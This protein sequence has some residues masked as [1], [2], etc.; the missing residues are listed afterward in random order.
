MRYNC[1]IR[2]DGWKIGKIRQYLDKNN[3]KDTLIMSY[4]VKY[5]S[6]MYGPFR[7]LYRQAQNWVLIKILIKWT[8]EILMKLLR[9]LF[10]Y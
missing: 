4:A 1:A 9:S 3:K 8:I 6:N 10:R 7:M 2:Y 5:S